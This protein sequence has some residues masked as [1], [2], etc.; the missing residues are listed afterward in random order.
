V[1]PASST[2]RV[3]VE[4][5]LQAEATDDGIGELQIEV[6]SINGPIPSWLSVAADGGSLTI[7][8]VTTQEYFG[9]VVQLEL[10]ATDG[11]LSSP[12]ETVTIT[13]N[14]LL[15]RSPNA[16]DLIITEIHHL[17]NFDTDSEFV[18]LMNVSD[19]PVDLRNYFLR[20]WGP[21]GEEDSSFGGPFLAYLA[22]PGASPS[23]YLL[24][25][26]DRLIVNLPG[27]NTQVPYASAAV[28]AATLEVDPQRGYLPLETV[29][30]DLWLFERTT[31]D[32]AFLVADF[33]AWWEPG[34]FNFFINELTNG[35]S[36]DLTGLMPPPMLG[37]WS[38]PPLQLEN[39][40][41]RGLSY[42]LAVE[43][44]TSG[45]SCWVVSGQAPGASCVGGFTT[46]GPLT[47]GQTNAQ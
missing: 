26:G 47:A 8:P 24:A 31:T 16:G 27:N 43:R 38:G 4:A 11:L 30:D 34:R 1:P 9:E 14:G 36:T 12:P 18:E 19:Q 15:G 13:V 41:D 25:P 7:S 22:A 23:E 40:R 29:G 28:A 2:W 42:S 37:V 46:A 44:D 21:N 32:G 33:V 45:A 3:G 17:A 6:T 10:V 39:Q 5:Q 20:D 35:N